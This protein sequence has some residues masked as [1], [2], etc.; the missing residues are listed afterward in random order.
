MVI[1][2]LQQN[3]ALARN[4]VSQM[5]E[6]LADRYWRWRDSRTR[7]RP[8]ERGPR[9][10]GLFPAYSDWGAGMAVDRDG[11]IWYS[12]DPEPWTNPGIVDDPSIRFAALGVA[13]CRH[14]ELSHV[15]PVRQASDPVCPTCDGR[16]YPAYLSP[17]VRY[18]V[19]CQCGGLG[20][21]PVSLSPSS[22]RSMIDIKAPAS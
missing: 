12:E 18:Y 16:G 8:W 15:R 13:V 10:H 6:W 22:L 9:A 14:P 21:V 7:P 5:F 20:W 4:K 17:R 11:E 1:A 2:R 19:V 3:L